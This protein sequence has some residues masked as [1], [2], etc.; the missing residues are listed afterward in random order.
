MYILAL[1]TTGA[2][3]SV[4][5]LDQ[6]GKV[7]G[8]RICQEPM[9]HLRNLIPM[10]DEVLDEGGV[11]KNEIDYVA[12]SAGPGSFTGIRIGVTTARALCQILNL[13]G[14]SVSTLEGFLR[15]EEAEQAKE[16]DVIC[17]AIINARRGQVYGVID[18]YMHPQACML[19]DVLT[20]IKEKIFPRGKK[21]LFFGDGIDAYQKLI[22]DQL[23]GKGIYSFASKDCRYQ[24]AV[25]VGKQAL[26]MVEEGKTVDYEGL[27]PQYMRKAEAEEKLAAGQLPICKGPRQE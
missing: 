27:L 8:Y 22:D 20:V 19:E 24:D 13:Q 2:L 15:K 10:V 26:K 1:E 14:V 11:S 23:E 6:D 25:S 3:G 4:A 5:L 12:T 17:C 9:S 7:L 21:V 18:Q 16:R